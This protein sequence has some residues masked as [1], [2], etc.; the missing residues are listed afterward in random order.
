MTFHVKV[1]FSIPRVAFQKIERK[2]NLRYEKFNQNKELKE[3]LIKTKDAKL[4]HFNDEK[5]IEFD[6][7]MSIR[8]RLIEK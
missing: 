4:V 6:N 1:Y 2:R 3:L 5:Q 7:L 8:K